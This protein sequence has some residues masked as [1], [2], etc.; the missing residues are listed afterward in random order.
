MK[1]GYAVQSQTRVSFGTK[2]T[3]CCR[4]HDLHNKHWVLI[5][6]VSL[7]LWMLFFMDSW[8]WR[9]MCEVLPTS[10]IIS[11]PLYW[12][13]ESLTWSY[14]RE[15]YEA[16]DPH[17]HGKIWDMQIGHFYYTI[18]NIFEWWPTRI[19]LISVKAIQWMI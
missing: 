14:H 9:K 12:A 11:V 13:I 4:I 17:R 10:V 18:T 19:F 1:W 2:L 16:H 5:R 7:T 8:T 15:D 6:K 3:T